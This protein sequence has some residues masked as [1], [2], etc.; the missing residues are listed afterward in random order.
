MKSEALSMLRRAVEE[1]YSEW[2]NL[3]R[4]PDLTC[5]RDEAE[6]QRLLARRGGS[7]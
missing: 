2:D 6:F 5:L 7:R 1:G 4:D 3:A